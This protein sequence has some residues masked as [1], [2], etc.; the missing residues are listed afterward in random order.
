MM[1]SSVASGSRPKRS[2]MDSMLWGGG[3]GCGCAERG[4]DVDDSCVKQD[5]DGSH[6]LLR[7]ANA[8]GGAEVALRVEVDHLA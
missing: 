1:L 2:Q 8:P 4:E 5:G 3:V 7:H 6:K